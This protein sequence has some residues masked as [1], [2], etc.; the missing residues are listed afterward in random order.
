MRVGVMATQLG[1]TASEWIESAQFFEAAGA[2]F[3]ALPDHYGIAPAPIPTLAVVGAGTNRLG[4]MTLTLNCG[5]RHDGSTI[6]DIATLTAAFG[7][8]VSIGLGVG[9]DPRDWTAHDEVMPPF[10]VRLDR[11]E[12]MVTRIRGGLEDFAAFAPRVRAHAPQLVVGGA[13]VRLLTFAA[14]HADTVSLGPDLARGT[15]DAES[16]ARSSREQVAQRC[17]LVAHHSEAL[18]RY[19]PI[20]VLVLETLVCSSAA[21]GYEQLAQRY[22][23]SPDLTAASPH[24]LA[25][26]PEEIAAKLEYWATDHHVAEVVLNQVDLDLSMADFSRL[27]GALREV[28]QLNGP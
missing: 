6:E 12:R 15:F 21:S 27:V 25:G 13:G 8:R 28:R 17:Q 16:V 23:T 7:Q 24:Y 5:I 26:P 1:A 20:Q 14:E 18:G 4:L 3:V 2:D 22:S 19:V 11:L 9:W 10:S